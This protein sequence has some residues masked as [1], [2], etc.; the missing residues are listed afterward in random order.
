MS[1]IKKNIKE[2]IIRP[3]RKFFRKLEKLHEFDPILSANRGIFPFA[4]ESFA[5]EYEKTYL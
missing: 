5:A 1:S 2:K 3:N 4:F